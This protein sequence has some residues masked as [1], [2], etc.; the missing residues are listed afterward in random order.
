MAKSKL[1]KTLEQ[2]RQECEQAGI[3]LTPKR[4]NVLSVLLSIGSAVSAYQIVDRYASEY[5]ES[6]K[7][8]SVYRILNFLVEAGL[9]H[10]LE[11]TNQY[12][13][14]SH[15]TCNHAHQIPQFLI[16][17]NCEQVTEVGLHKTLVDELKLSVE[18]SGFQLSSQQL[19]LR[20][21]CKRCRG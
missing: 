6:L 10:R 11:T 17:N 7:A 21:L 13:A 4:I 5:G 9:V 15:I 18:D 20:G 3:R 2:A 12:I 8:M 16:C 19:E 14:C 1:Q